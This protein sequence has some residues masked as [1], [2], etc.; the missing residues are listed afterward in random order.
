MTFFLTTY[1]E[2]TFVLR[3]LLVKF[4]QMTHLIVI[5]SNDVDFYDTGLADICSNNIV[6][7]PFVLKTFVLMTFALKHL[8][9]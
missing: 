8:S 3:T 1:F 5:C 6:M 9:P 4:V 2:M 7:T